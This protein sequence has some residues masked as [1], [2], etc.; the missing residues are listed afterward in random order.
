MVG[1]PNTYMGISHKETPDLAYGSPHGGTQVVGT[2]NRKR[3][4]QRIVL[5]AKTGQCC[6]T[7]PERQPAQP[8]HH[9][10]DFCKLPVHN[11]WIP[12]THRRHHS[13]YLPVMDPLSPQTTT[14]FQL[15]LLINQNGGGYQTPT[16]WLSDRLRIPC[17]SGSPHGGTQVVGTTNRNDIFNG[18][19]YGQRQVNVA[20]LD[21]SG[22]LHNP[23]ITQTISVNYQSTTGGYQTPTGDKTILSPR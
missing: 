23:P 10:N 13:Y 5:W 19:S 20:L 3:H 9:P 12:D 18:L 8:T 15:I 2:T 11:W 17:L 4:I 16:C 6:P 21:Q 7:R 22:N 14:I 1:I